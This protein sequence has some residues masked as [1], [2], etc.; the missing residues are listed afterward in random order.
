MRQHAAERDKRM[1]LDGT[2]PGGKNVQRVPPWA[3]NS[4]QFTKDADWIFHVL[5]HFIG[6]NEIKAVV[7]ERQFAS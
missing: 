1:R 5:D 4:E 7:I 3:G 2:V 6:D